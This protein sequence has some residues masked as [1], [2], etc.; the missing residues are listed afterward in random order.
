MRKTGFF[1]CLL[2][3]MGIFGFAQ[4]EGSIVEEFQ[5]N[6]SWGDLPTKI[7]ILKDSE[8][9]PDTD[10]APLY[11]QSLHFV[12]WKVPQLSSDAL[13]RELATLTVKLIGVAKV[14]KAALLL[15][16]LFRDYDLPAIRL[17]ILTA[18]GKIAQGDERII[19]ALC[20]WMDGRNELFKGGYTVDLELLGAVITLL[21]TLESETS[22]PY[23]F[24]TATLGYS[25]ETRLK[26]E[27]ALRQ[28]KGDYGKMIIPILRNNPLAEKN[29]MLRFVMQKENIPWK[30]KAQ[31]A[32]IALEIALELTVGDGE[33]QETLL[34]F[35]R[36]AVGL[37]IDTD[38]RRAVTP[39]IECFDDT[40]LS[41]EKGIVPLNDILQTMN[42]LGKTGSPE[43]AERLTLYIGLLNLQTENGQTVDEEVIL[44]VI[45]NL[46]LLGDK[47]AFDQLLYI[48]YLEYS[49][50]IKRAAQKA[51]DK[52]HR[53]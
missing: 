45:H 33:E 7:Q 1:I 32:Q 49:A 26:A 16:D 18:L 43:A 38:S 31:I 4:T 29:F 37:L 5:R 24:T 15:W 41:W 50:E 8:G 23:L 28:I 36:N 22:F 53:S 34:Q 14:K 20:Q 6:F 44:T 13:S 2:F 51:I 48:R 39:L 9:H 52:L 19:T 3:L 11:L 21:G 42:A 30:T 40:L 46:S 35:R 10:M 27:A 25:V 12:I 47:I 17:E